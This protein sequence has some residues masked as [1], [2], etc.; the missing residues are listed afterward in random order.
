MCIRRLN[1]SPH[2]SNNNKMSRQD[3]K[4]R[5][6]S[7][8]HHDKNTLAVEKKG[9]VELNK[10]KKTA[11]KKKKKRRFSKVASVATYVTQS[12]LMVALALTR[13]VVRK[14]RKRRRSSICDLVEKENI[15]PTQFIEDDDDDSVVSTWVDGLA[16]SGELKRRDP[17][18]KGTQVRAIHAVY[19]YARS[20]STFRILS[21]LLV[22]LAL[23]P[24]EAVV[25]MVALLVIGTFLH[26][27][28][29]I[30]QYHLPKPKGSLYYLRRTIVWEFQSFLNGIGQTKY[31]WA[32]GFGFYL[33]QWTHPL[34]LI[35]DRQMRRLKRLEKRNL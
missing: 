19:E 29:L 34:E 21:L 3:R 22:L 30:R 8:H 18:S 32:L 10:N 31:F 33:H 25:G 14:S 27:F 11:S 23:P 26:V 35:R 5:R 15:L 4:S 9:D 24:L 1:F 20:L 17:E 12:P 28:H 2:K 16:E 13:V 6:H 7:S